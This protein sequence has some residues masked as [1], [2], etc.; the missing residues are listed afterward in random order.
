MS[1]A[2]FFR[3]TRPCLDRDGS[4]SK[5][6]SGIHINGK[7]DDPALTMKMPHETI[8][9]FLPKYIELHFGREVNER[10]TNPKNPAYLGDTPLFEAIKEG[11]ETS[12]FIICHFREL[13][14]YNN[15]SVQ[16]ETTPS[17]V[18]SGKT[19]TSL[20]RRLEMLNSLMEDED[21]QPYTP[22]CL[23]VERG[24]L[25]ICE[26]LIQY[27]AKANQK[28]GFGDTPLCNAYGNE[29][30][31][32][33]L[34]RHGASANKYNKQ[35]SRQEDLPRTPLDAFLESLRTGTSEAKERAKRKLPIILPH[36]NNR[37]LLL[38]LQWTMEENHD[39]YYGVCFHK[40]R[41]II[42]E[43]V[44]RQNFP[45]I[46]NRYLQDE[47]RVGNRAEFM[48]YATARC[49]VL[50]AV[51]W[52]CERRVL[53]PKWCEKALSHVL[54]DEA[55]HDDMASRLAM[56]S[57]LLKTMGK[58]PNR[59]LNQRL[60]HL[61]LFCWGTKSIEFRSD[62][63]A[64][65]IVDLLVGAGANVNICS[66]NWDYPP[67][68]LA[69]I[70]NLPSDFSS[71]SALI[72]S[73]LKAGANVHAEYDHDWW[74]ASKTALHVIAS[75]KSIGTAKL[76]LKH[77][78]NIN[79]RNYEDLTPL[80]IAMHKKQFKMAQ[81]LIDNG[82]DVNM[83]FQS[84]ITAIFLAVMIGRNDPEVSY[85]L[86]HAL[87][88]RKDLDVKVTI[89]AHPSDCG[90]TPLGLAVLDG[91][92]DVVRILIQ[93]GANVNAHMYQRLSLLDVAVHQ[94][95]EREDA[96]NGEEGSKPTVTI[97][98]RLKIVELLK[99]NGAKS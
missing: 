34:L 55:L 30:I 88:Q 99:A 47:V 1:S 97:A 56:V 9:A 11:D 67:L 16:A 58:G 35:A 28:D 92:V 78:A 93:H 10:K 25:S 73:I 79:E 32:K 72:K 48:L 90:A 24:D 5:D 66:R 95:R 65:E 91:L 77:G 83:E 45:D 46:H 68:L 36:C 14:G 75:T 82:A 2:G 8:L 86:L 52:L 96:T 29:A 87:F 50:D 81:F 63:A 22:L 98:T 38:Y 33:L 85:S 59:I 64:G 39:D 17:K 23:A 15:C 20:P 94:L 41:W 71:E 53:S 3:S 42:E 69:A 80:H 61:T 37:T 74:N 44:L 76:L 84:G 31:I 49:N 54:D 27:G 60:L 51:K 4:E 19:L 89:D 62:C 57:V 13:L 43:L 18:M 70:Q 7:V 12:L 6:H 26:L 40:V 21:G